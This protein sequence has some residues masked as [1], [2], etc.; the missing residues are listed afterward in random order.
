[1]DKLQ[2][3]IRA[4]YKKKTKYDV[5]VTYNMSFLKMVGMVFLDGS[6]M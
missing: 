4:N 3:F 1:M 6:K 5:S 2:K